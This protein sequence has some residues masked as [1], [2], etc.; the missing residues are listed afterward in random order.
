MDEINFDLSASNK[1]S[2]LRSFRCSF[3]DFTSIFEISF[4]RPF[5]KIRRRAVRLSAVWLNVHIINSSDTVNGE[6]IFV[7]VCAIAISVYFESCVSVC[8]SAPEY[9]CVRVV[10]APAVDVVA[11]V[12]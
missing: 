12:R 9:V 8:A 6:R 5:K 3:S 1:L 10:R 7:C 4:R 11:F 2:H